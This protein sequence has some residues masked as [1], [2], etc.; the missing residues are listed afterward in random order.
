MQHIDDTQLHEI[1]HTGLAKRNWRGQRVL[2]LIPDGTRTMPLPRYFALVRA[3]LRE[4]GAAAQTWMV[5]LGTH[6]AMDEAALDQLL[7]CDLAALRHTEPDIA[8]VNHAWQDPQSLVLVGTLSADE[9]QRLS[10]G[11]STEAVPV[12]VNR[13]VLTHDHILICGPVFPHEVVGFSG[14]N[15]YLFP[16]ISGP[17]VIN[18][19]HWL[20]ALLTSYAIIGTANTAVRAVIDA[21]A[22]LIPTPRFAICS[23]VTTDGVWGTFVDTPEV[24]WQDAAACSAEVHVRWLTAP[25]QRV[26]AVLPPMYD[27]L[28]VG[29]KGMYK[30]EPVVA[31]GGEV[32]IYAP[33][34]REVSVVHGNVIREIGY[35]VRDYFLAQWDRFGHLPKGVIAH[36]THLRGVGT[37]VNGVERPRIRVTLATGISAAECAQINL[38]YMDYRSIDPVALAAADDPQTLV[39]PRA[40]E[41]LYRL[42]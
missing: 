10:G 42:R 19:T 37:Y 11:M 16:G 34:L 1:V 20:G 27:E 26:I 5:A 32:V 4:A 13:A 39:I 23:V 9:M 28:W 7:G 24:A 17:D 38:G 33:H 31:D 8:V 21:A 40:G 30:S 29:S 18:A 25:V 12:R 6:P 41:Y 15:K 35:H 3:A 22:A 2:V 14:G 36:S